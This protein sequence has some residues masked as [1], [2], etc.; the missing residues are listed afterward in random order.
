MVLS[1]TVRQLA[2][3]RLLVSGPADGYFELRLLSPPAVVHL[4]FGRFARAGPSAGEPGGT[5]PSSVS[6]QLRD[7]EGEDPRGLFWPPAAGTRS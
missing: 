7:G 6:A 3:R 2:G 5:V 1:V 4:Y